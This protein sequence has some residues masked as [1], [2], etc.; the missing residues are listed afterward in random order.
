MKVEEVDKKRRTVSSHRNADNLLE[1]STSKLNKYVVDKKLQ[2]TDH[3]FFC[4]ACFTFLFVTINEICLMKSQSNKFIAY[5][6]IFMLKGIVDNFFK[7]IF[8][9]YMGNGGIQG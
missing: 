8:Q 4:V 2:H 3:L 6:T 9:F 1:K 5:A 7:A